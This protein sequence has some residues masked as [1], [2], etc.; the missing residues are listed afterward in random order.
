MLLQN[1]GQP[2]VHC[3]NDLRLLGGCFFKAFKI[4]KINGLQESNGRFLN[5][6]LGNWV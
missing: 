3:F 4:I 1:Y 2:I 5:S 6:Q